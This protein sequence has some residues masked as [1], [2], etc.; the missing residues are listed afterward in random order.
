[1]GKQPSKETLTRFIGDSIESD[2]DLTVTIYKYETKK[3]ID[4]TLSNGSEQAYF[5]YPSWG[6]A[7]SGI[8]QL[9]QV[10][11]LILQ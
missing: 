3:L 9:Q 11:D 4:I 7:F 6:K 2:T 8:V 5:T 1:M 10:V